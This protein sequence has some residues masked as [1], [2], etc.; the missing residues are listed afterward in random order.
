MDITAVLMK[1]GKSNDFKILEEHAEAFKS[2]LSEAGPQSQRLNRLVSLRTGIEQQHGDGALALLGLMEHEA[3]LH[4]VNNLAFF[5][6]ELIEVV[7]DPVGGPRLVIEFIRSRNP[8]PGWKGS[9]LGGMIQLGDKRVNRLLLE[10]WAELDDEERREATRSNNPSAGIMEG[11]LDFYVS[12]L[13]QGCED[14]IFGA[15]VGSMCRIPGQAGSPVAVDIE[16]ILPTYRA[17]GMPI[18]SKSVYPKTE[19]LSR[20]RDRLKRIEENETEPKLIPM[21]YQFW[22]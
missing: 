17:T 1:I 5:A 9:A 16:R 3:D 2:F 10:L 8:V 21:V 19:L 4:M 12:C 20:F 6:S 7:G 15:I 14:D 13:E 11:I 22:A 18:V